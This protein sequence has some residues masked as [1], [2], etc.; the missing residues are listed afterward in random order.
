MSTDN[1]QSS[2]VNKA[3]VDGFTAIGGRFESVEKELEALKAK[4]ESKL[5]HAMTAKVEAPD[6]TPLAEF[7]V[8]A[9]ERMSAESEA[10]ARRLDAT[11]KQ[12]YD[13]SQAQIKSQQEV[14]SAMEHLVKALTVKTP[15]VVN[16]DSVARA[17][18]QV[19]KALSGVP[20]PVTKVV[21]QDLSPLYDLIAEVKRGNDLVERALR[22]LTE[23]MSAKKQEITAKFN[24]DGSGFTLARH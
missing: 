22:G 5:L 7:L 8:K 3:V 19:H 16:N 11:Q 24:E 20:A 17:I 6:L 4:G 14:C 15:V 12:C 13:T 2:P 23:A 18:T 9:L 10:T 21:Q 1:G